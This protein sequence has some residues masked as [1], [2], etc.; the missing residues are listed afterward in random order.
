MAEEGE[1]SSEGRL[2]WG[3]KQKGKA[4][5]VCFWGGF[6]ASTL[7]H[8]ATLCTR[9]RMH[10]AYG[11]R[12]AAAPPNQRDTLCT[13]RWQT[14][15]GHMSTRQMVTRGGGHSKWPM[16]HSVWA[17]QGPKHIL[18]TLGNGSKCPGL[19]FFFLPRIK[20]DSDLKSRKIY[21]YDLQSDKCLRMYHRPTHVLH[22]WMTSPDLNPSGGHGKKKLP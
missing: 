22:I 6:C 7:K 8:S 15:N 19:N 14:W 10:A 9:P 1:R 16:S 11:S 18:A 20:D 5:C 12:N 17:L 3:L 2:W 13:Q 4:V 21:L